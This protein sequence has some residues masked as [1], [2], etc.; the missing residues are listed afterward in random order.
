MDAPAVPGF[1]V[2]YE[3]SDGQV[4]ATLVSQSNPAFTLPRYG[5]GASEAQA[6]ASAARRWQV[7]QV[8]SEADRRQGERRLP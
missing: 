8:G 2:V 4:W 6:L 7:E 5:S 1:D 3:E